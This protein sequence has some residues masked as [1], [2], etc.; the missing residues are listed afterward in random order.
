MTD[1]IKVWLVDETGIKAYAEGADQRDSLIGR[2]WAECGEPV[3]SEFVWCSHADIA[4]PA[5]FPAETLD[6]WT[7]RGWVPGPPPPPDNHFSAVA[8][9]V[10]ESLPATEIKPKPAA[11]GASTK[12]N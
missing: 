10:T 8:P 9:A 6:Y 4:V 12:E 3:G 5:Y 1:K 11:G 2:G 7:T